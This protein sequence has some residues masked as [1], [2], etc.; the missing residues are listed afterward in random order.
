MNGFRQSL[1][2]KGLFRNSYLTMA[3]AFTVTGI[4]T[5]MIYLIFFHAPPTLGE[6]LNEFGY[7]E[8][9]PPSK[10]YGPGTFNSVEQVRDQSVKLHPTCNMDPRILEGLW[11]ESPTV[12]Q[13]MTARFSRDFDISSELLKSL[14]SS[15]SGKQIEDVH[16]S[17]RNM[18]IVVLTQENLLKLRDQYLKGTCEEAIIENVRNGACVRQSEEVLQADLV[19]I[20][21]VEDT[22]NSTHHNS[23]ARQEGKVTL[24]LGGGGTTDNTVRGAELFYGVK[25][26][27]RCVMIDES[28]LALSKR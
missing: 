8:I 11:N 10:L 14:K 1:A 19:Y 13:E 9:V 20:D 26:S 17:L 2:H 3:V 25:L 15:M 21:R 16:L 23:A 4:A 18:R 6:V 27:P 22:V 7:Q 12:Q 5:L 28:T 24:D